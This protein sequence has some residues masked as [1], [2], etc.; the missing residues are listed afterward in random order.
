MKAGVGGARISAVLVAGSQRARAQ[1]VVDALAVQTAVQVLEIVVV[2]LAP[3]ETDRLRIPELVN[4][5]YASRPDIVRW[6]VARAEGARLASG[7]IVAFIEDHCFPARDWAEVLIEAY[8][9]PWAG[10]GYAFTNANPESYISRSSLMA[11]Y[12]SFVH[13]AR[14]GRAGLLSGNNVSYRRDLLLSFGSALDDLLAI[15]FNFQEVLNK[16]GIAMFVESRAVAAH[17]NFTSVT[18]EGITGH[19]YC[20]LLAAKRAETQS[21]TRTRRLIHGIGAP[22]G[23]PAIRLGRLL[24]GL[25]GRSELWVT[26]ALG[27][28][29]IAVEYLFDA[30]GESLGYLFGAG[31]AER[32][33]LRWELE[34]ERVGDR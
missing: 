9:S 21:W 23:S 4:H 8:S 28:P 12:G 33:T 1:R 26:V 30:L 11:R 32:E 24:I 25:R 19:H 6:G 16:R 7:E 17:Q 29:V 18:K 20:R 15:D 34:T 22:L 2:D 3:P 5:A 13:P 27:L 14:R 10:I 31:T